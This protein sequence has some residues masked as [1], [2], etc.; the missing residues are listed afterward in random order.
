M[1]PCRDL[2]D[3]EGLVGW[4]AVPRLPTARA[5]AWHRLR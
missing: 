5:R 3:G 1:K 2:F 4:H